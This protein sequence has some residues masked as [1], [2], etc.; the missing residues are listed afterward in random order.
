L[1]PAQRILENEPCVNVPFFASRLLNT[2]KKSISLE[3][4]LEKESRR[5]LANKDMDFVKGGL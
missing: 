2:Q 1:N 3:A 4:D 5:G